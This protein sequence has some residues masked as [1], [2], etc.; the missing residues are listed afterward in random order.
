L[1]YYKNNNKMM[2]NHKRKLC[3]RTNPNIKITLEQHHSERIKDF[4]K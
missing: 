2:I 3:S 1:F 4:E